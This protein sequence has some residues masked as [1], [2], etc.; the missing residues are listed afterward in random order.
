PVLVW[1]D[2]GKSNPT[3]AKQKN[4]FQIVNER[5]KACRPILFS[6]NEDIESLSERIGG[7]TW[8]RL[9]GMSGKYLLATVGADYRLSRVG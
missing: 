9:V 2:L 7:A 5:Y 4:Y 8:S 3:Q 1:D 6:S